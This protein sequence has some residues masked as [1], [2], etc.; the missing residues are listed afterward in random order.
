[1]TLCKRTSKVGGIKRTSGSR[2]Y[3]WM[4]RENGYHEA[5][6]K[7][8]V[9]VSDER[10]RSLIDSALHH[11]KRQ[12]ELDACAAIGCQKAAKATMRRRWHGQRGDINME[13]RRDSVVNECLLLGGYLCAAWEKSC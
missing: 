6:F 9:V 7:T 11:Q 4:A 10:S 1:M 5:L 3:V 13:C 8:V 2:L 12:R